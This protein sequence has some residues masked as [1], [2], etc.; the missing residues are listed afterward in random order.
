M[1]PHDVNAPRPERPR[2]KLQGHP[3]LGDGS[4]ERDRGVVLGHREG[5]DRRRHR[6]DRG[7][8]RD[9]VLGRRRVPDGG[10]H[11]R[12]L[13]RGRRPPRR[14]DPVPARLL[15]GVHRA[16]RRLDDGGLQRDRDRGLGHP[17][18]GVGATRPP[19]HRRAVPRPD[20][21]L[22]LCLPAVPRAGRFARRAL[23]G[24]LPRRRRGGGAGPRVRR[25]GVHRPQAGPGRTRTASRAGASSRSPSS[26]GASTA[27]S[28][29]ARRSET[30]RT[31]SSAPTG[32]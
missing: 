6:G 19:A 5:H 28:G 4:A 32:R 14:R 24:R 17:R 8:L 2:M 21:H 31:S 27:S 30:G 16:A 10:G 12:A 13:H 29:C 26:R 11:V 3:D 25:D 23:P 22:H 15:C 9:P 7:V 18:Q 1:R 20:P